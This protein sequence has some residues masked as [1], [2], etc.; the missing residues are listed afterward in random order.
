MIRKYLFSLIA[1]FLMVNLFAQ[2]EP[3]LRCISLDENQDATLSWIQPADTGS[4]F[5]AYLLYYRNNVANSFSIVS[6]I[7]DFNQTSVLVN[8]NYATFGQFTLVQVVNGFVDTSAALDTVSPIV[9]GISSSGRVVSL[10]W[11]N[12]GLESQDSI[13]RLYKSDFLG[14]WTQLETFDFPLTAAHDTT[15][16]CKEEV[17]YRVEAKGVGGCVSRSNRATKNVIDDLAPAQTNLLCASVDTANGLVNLE[18]S[19]S[20]SEDTYGYMLFYF[21]DFNRT[22]TIFGSDSLS[23]TY[24][25]NGIDALLRP[26]TLSVAPFDSCFDSVNLWYNQA[27]DSLRFSTMFIDTAAFDKCSGK[28]AFEWPMPR[29]GF[30][31]GVRNL[32]GFRVYRQ[33]N[34]E[35][36]QV[37]SVLSSLDSVFLDSGLVAGNKYTYVICPFDEITGKEALSNKVVIDL[38]KKNSPDYLYIKSIV[39][40]HESGLNAINVYADTT[41]ETVAY[42]LWRSMTMDNKFMKVEVVDEDLTSEFS[43]SD[44]SGSASQTPY[45]YQV[46]AYDQ[47]NE[48]IGRSQIAKSVYVQGTK[49]VQDLI[50]KVTWTNYEGFDTADTDVDFYNL[51]RVTTGSNEDL[52]SSDERT[53]KYTDNLEAIDLVSGSICYYVEAQE[54]SG[55]VYGFN[56][57]SVSNLLCFDYPPT[58]FLPNAFTPDDDGRNDSFLPFVNFIDPTNYELVIYDRTGLLIFKTN[59]PF[60]GWSGDSQNT[61]I[62]AYRLVLSNARGETM[63][64]AGKVQLIR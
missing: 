36:P 45:Y 29:K 23:Y 11:N 47:C 59:D 18:W 63:N 21:E 27:A 60:E 41:A 24:Y 9:L 10:G 48:V 52:L 20:V 14:N 33:D 19:K 64:Y 6:Q 16:A 5:N 7:T 32:S 34:N 56:A 42:G 51:Y 57:A 62:Y 43:I 49:N 46:F 37:I 28:L 26:E 50:N 55:N 58:V 25:K 1:I 15:V 8:G 2:T 53:F 31:V 13:Y 54:T 12:S 44:E 35:T 38:G 3:S 22:D 4:D 30:P 40:N 39:N 61:G 17:L